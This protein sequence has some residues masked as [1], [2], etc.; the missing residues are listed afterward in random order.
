MSERCF[1]DSNV[2]VYAHD[3][4]AGERHR[5]ARDLVLGLWRERNGVVSTQVL[6]ET[7]VNVRRKAGHPLSADTARSL[8]RDYLA[9]EVVVNDGEAVVEAT[10]LEERYGISFWDALIVH[11][12]NVSRST[13]LLTEDL[14][15]GQHYGGVVAHNPFL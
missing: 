4:S 15:H 12:A 10:R 11:A 13:T 5:V 1:V 2:L 8:L 14:S 3:T 7:Y 9:W 6:Q